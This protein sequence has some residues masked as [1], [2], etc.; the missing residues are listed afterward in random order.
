MSLNVLLIKRNNLHMLS[1]MSTETNNPKMG[2]GTS[3]IREKYILRLDFCTVPVS[4]KQRVN[5]FTVRDHTAQQ[6]AM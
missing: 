4:V 2:A 5:I 3:V 1:N 6:L